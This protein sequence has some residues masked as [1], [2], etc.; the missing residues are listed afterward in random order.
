MR[1]IAVANQKGGVGKTTVTLN[2]AAEL[3]DL[4]KR[5]LAIDLD[6]QCNLTDGLGVPQQACTIYNVMI[7]EAPITDARARIRNFDIVVGSSALLAAETQ[8]LMEVER[9]CRLRDALAPVADEYDFVLIDCPPALGVLTLNALVAADDVLAPVRTA[10]WDY[11][12]LG[13][14]RT[15]VAKIQRRLNPRLRLRHIVPTLYDRTKGAAKDILAALQLLKTPETTVHDPISYTTRISEA[16][17]AKKPL[18][19]YDRSTPAADAF[20]HLAARVITASDL[21]SA[22]VS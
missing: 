4:G 17:M 15:N 3:A 22:N 5:V 9:E 6:A 1:I 11:L 16:S 19:D 12:A 7:S 14:L 18:R 2:L 10:Q 8:L 13:P 21:A 20:E